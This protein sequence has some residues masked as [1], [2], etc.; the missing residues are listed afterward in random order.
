[1]V[2]AT[3]ETLVRS[4][5]HELRG[6]K[7]L[8]RLVPYRDSDDQIAGVVL[9]FVDVTTLVNAEAHHKVLIAELN[10]RVK[11]MLMVV[12]SIA[13]H[14]KNADG[15]TVL[16][17]APKGEAYTNTFSEKADANLKAMGLDYDG[18]N[19]Q[20]ITVKLNPGGI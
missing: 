13:E 4:V 19:F 18:T 3:G 2:F 8:L 5:D 9:T 14:T 17:G 12:I 1:M 10:H 11:N 20:P 6:A 15:D 16:K 7:Y